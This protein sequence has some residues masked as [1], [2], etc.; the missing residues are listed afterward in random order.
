MI[1]CKNIITKI[2]KNRTHIESWER[3][4]SKLFSLYTKAYIIHKQSIFQ[5]KNIFDDIFHE[6]SRLGS[7][8]TDYLC[9]F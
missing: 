8:E 9:Y 3:I 1:L 5:K 2:D 7:D 6:Q 4:V